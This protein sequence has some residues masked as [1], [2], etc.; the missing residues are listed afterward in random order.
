[1][2]TISSAASRRR[3]VLALAMV[4][5]V[6]GPSTIAAQ[7]L[8][9]LFYHVDTEESF[10]SF[11]A[12]ADRIAGTISYARSQKNNHALSEGAALWTVGLLLH[13]AVRVTRAIRKRSPTSR[14]AT[15]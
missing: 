6:T 11:R 12:H 5:A 9:R 10:E 4:L 3:P 1:M 7:S 14:C 2:P 15:T 13:A 8:E